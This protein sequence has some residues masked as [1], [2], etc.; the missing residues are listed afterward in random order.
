MK[1]GKLSSLFFSIAKRIFTQRHE[2]TQRNAKKELTTD[3]TTR[4]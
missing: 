4:E 1:H 2:G 3:L